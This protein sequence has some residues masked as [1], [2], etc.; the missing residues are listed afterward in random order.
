M[1]VTEVSGTNVLGLNDRPALDVYLE[2][3]NAPEDA[4]TDAAAFARFAL[5]RPFGI[6]TRAGE[7]AVR[8]VAAADFDE[9]SLRTIAEI[10]QGILT[11]MM[12]GGID[13]VLGATDAACADALAA[14]GGDPP[15]GMLAFN[16]IGRR[17]VLGKT[18]VTRELERIANC[19]SGAPLAGFYNYGGIART[20]GAAG[21]HNHSLVLLALS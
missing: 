8:L 20:R 9:R 13:S 7:Y 21:F 10:P 14:L 6:S 4:R 15:L 19:G 11:W 5:T 3:T 12:R 16:G 1:L 2:R 17:A 18:G